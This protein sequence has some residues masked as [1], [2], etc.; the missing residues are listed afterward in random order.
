MTLTRVFPVTSREE[1]LFGV[2]T[3]KNGSGNGDRKYKHTLKDFSIKENRE[4]EMQLGMD[5][6]SGEGFLR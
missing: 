3:R 2:V 4:M 1:C 5:L 6:G